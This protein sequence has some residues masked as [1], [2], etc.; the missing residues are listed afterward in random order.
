MPNHFHLMIQQ[1]TERAIVE[2]MRR[3]SN[4][5]IKYFNEKYKRV[6]SLFQGRYKAALIRKERHFLYL[7][8]YIHH[9]PEKLNKKIKSYPYSSYGDYSGTR[10]TKWIYKKDLME[11]FIEAENQEID[12]EEAKNILGKITLE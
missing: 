4:A 7:P 12:I 5:Y 10:N 11:Q 9:N 8:Y 6:G 2:F 1:L 3:L